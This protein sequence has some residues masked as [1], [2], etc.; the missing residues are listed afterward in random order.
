[1]KNQEKTLYFLNSTV[2]REGSLHSTLLIQKGGVQKRKN[3]LLKI[4]NVGI[5]NL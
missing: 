2:G 1:M 5:I 4:E 3:V